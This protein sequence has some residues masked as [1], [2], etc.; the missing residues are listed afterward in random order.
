M[1]VAA[2]PV[3]EVDRAAVQRWL[4]HLDEW[5]LPGSFFGVQHT[6]PQLYRSDGRGRFFVIRD[7]DR[8]LSHCASRAVTVH[9]GAAAFRACLIGS[10]VTDPTFRGAGLA[11]AVLAAALHANAADAPFALLWAE[12]PELYARAG[13]R[14]GRDETSLV[15]ARR[16]RPALAG[17]RPL[18]IDDHAAAHALHEQKPFR[19][20]RTPAAMSALLTTPGMT[21][22]ALERDGNVV[23]YACCGKGADLQGHWHELGGSD[24]DLARLLPAAL[25]VAEQSRAMLLLPPW[26]ARL[27]ELLAPW[28]VDTIPVTGPMWWSTGS[29]LPPCWIDGLDSV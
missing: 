16:P 11:S 12:L 13:F 27:R 25:H 8:L 5:L 9:A 15:L 18:T 2:P 22:L 14:T 1:N 17:V 19:V 6:W 10:V 4:P 7:G 26:R 29:E 21:N 24:D 3:H 23:A 20:E 28:T